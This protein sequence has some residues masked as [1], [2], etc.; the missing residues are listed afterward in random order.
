MYM[1]SPGD[2]PVDKV[3]TVQSLDAAG[4]NGPRNCK[5]MLYMCKCLSIETLEQL[6]HV[7][8]K[9]ILELTGHGEVALRITRGVLATLALSL[10][11]D[12]KN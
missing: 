6:L 7:D 9:R 5:A 10:K 11:A 8:P 4:M 3:F 1:G 12:K 2:M